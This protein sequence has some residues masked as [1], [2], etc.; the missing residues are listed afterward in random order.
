VEPWSD[1]LTCARAGVPV[2]QGDIALGN[3]QLIVR[4]RSWT[5]TD[6]RVTSVTEDKLLECVVQRKDELTTPL[7]LYSTDQLDQASVMLAGLYPDGS[8]LFYSLKANPQPG[9]V[10][11][12]AGKGIRPEIA[13][14]GERQICLQAGVAPE[15]I[16]VGGVSKSSQYLA[17]VCNSGCYAI[18]VDSLSEW[19]RLKAII[20]EDMQPSILLRIAPG[21]PL[22]GLDMAGSSQFGLSHEQ[23]VRVAHECDA[24]NAKFLGLHFYF[25]SQRLSN[26]PILKTLRVVVK[27]L[28]AFNAEGLKV[29]VVDVGLG[30][31]VPYLEKDT[32]LDYDSLR[33][34]V[35][36]IWKDPIW[37]GVEIWSEAGRALVGG[38]GYYVSRVTDIKRLHGKTFVFLD[39]GINTHNPG[40]GLGR[41]FRSNPRFLFVTQAESSDSI[42]VDLVGNLCTST[43][44]IGRDVETPRLHEGDLVVIPNSGAYTQTTGMW[45]FN[46]QRPFS[47]MLLGERGDPVML[48]PQ[49][50]LWLRANSSHSYF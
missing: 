42:V 47:E 48:E 27:T 8:Q 43:D 33:N 28:Q 14:A 5:T 44:V 25:G 39:G 20:S 46:S 38:A 31:G 17:D 26:E 19:G 36:S 45:G 41:F 13:S 23:A 9:I 16:L 37:D 2:F 35:H 30:C 11:H 29:Q 15:E 22:G 24:R 6:G 1:L 7:Y 50:E 49:Y 3:L 10:R 21:I 4:I 34:Q 18:V 12:F 40:V 32:A